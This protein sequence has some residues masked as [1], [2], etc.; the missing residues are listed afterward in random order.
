MRIRLLKSMGASVAI[1]AVLVLLIP[2]QVTAA[3]QAPTAS[4]TAPASFAVLKTPWGEPDLQGI[5]TD[6]TDTPLQRSPKYANQ[7]FFTDAQREELDNERS[8]LLR[9]D[10]RV[11]RG[12]ELD[13]A[14]AYNAV[15][16][17][18][19]RTGARTSLMV[20][21]ADGRLPPPTPQ[22][23]KLLPPSGNF[24]LRCCRRQRHARII[25]WPVAEGNT[26]R[27]RLC[28]APTFLLVT[29]PRVSIAMM[30]RRMARWGT[31]A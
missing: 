25:R 14:G 23:A 8:A 9:R 6:E 12:T 4:R 15:F 10:R 7:E 22:A 11:E 28:D 31:A 24:A 27:R 16:M 17:S 5:W 19:K 13:V 30:A 29:T 18:M 20:D 1:V 26:I 3:D 2:A 21:P